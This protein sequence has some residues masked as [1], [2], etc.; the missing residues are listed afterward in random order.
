[1]NLLE[2]I[3]YGIETQTWVNGL[4]R[5]EQTNCKCTLTEEGY[6]I[7]RTPNAPYP[8]SGST[9]WGGFV[10][11][12]ASMTGSPDISI[13]EDNH[14]Y[15]MCIDVK[16]ISSYGATDVYW[17]NNCGWGGHGLDPRPTDVVMHNPIGTDFN[18]DKWE[19]FMYKFSV[20]DGIMKE[21]TS[22][23]SNFSAG[24]YYNSYRDFKFGYT[25]K[26]TGPNGT[27]IYLKNIRM[28]DITNMK[29]MDIK[30]TGVAEYVAMIENE[31]K[32][33]NASVFSFGELR[34][35]NFYEI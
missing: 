4:S 1:M 13:L 24:T 32:L 28:Y 30:K 15:L 29:N 10:I 5:Y 33:G 6:R 26:D 9:M 12:T 35:D 7:Y 20:T 11:R 19:T 22:S 8:G 25:Y 18:S 17:T 21:C 14:T 27:D 31:S 16:G 23:Y 34:A 3:N 2:N